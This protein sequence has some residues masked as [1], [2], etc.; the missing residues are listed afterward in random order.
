MTLAPN[1]PP[2]GGGCGKADSAVG[3][4]FESSHRQLLLNNFLLLTVCRKNIK[5]RKRGQEWTLIFEKL[6][7]IL[8]S[9]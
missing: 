1:L 9:G 4:R 7:V 8:I 5:K 6:T 3:L 2:T